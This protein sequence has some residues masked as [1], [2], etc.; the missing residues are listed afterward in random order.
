MFAR[1]LSAYSLHTE[2]YLVR[3]KGARAG[4]QTSRLYKIFIFSSLCEYGLIMAVCIRGY[5]GVHNCSL[6]AILLRTTAGHVPP[7]GWSHPIFHSDVLSFVTRSLMRN[8]TAL[9]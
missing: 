7:L 5:H 6:G 4:V 1:A 8:I 9:I 3:R 2:S